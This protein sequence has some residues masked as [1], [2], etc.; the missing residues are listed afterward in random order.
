MPILPSS[1]LHSVQSAVNRQDRQG[2]RAPLRHRLAPCY[3]AHQ[4]ICSHHSAHIRTVSRARQEVPG[5]RRPS[6]NRHNPSPCRPF[7]GR[8]GGRGLGLPPLPFLPPTL[9]SVATFLPRSCHFLPLL[10]PSRG[11]QPRQ[12]PLKSGI[13]QGEHPRQHH[14]AAKTAM[15]TAAVNIA[16]HPGAA[17]TVGLLLCHRM[18]GVLSWP[19]LASPDPDLH[20]DISPIS[21]KRPSP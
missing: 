17:S 8:E 7:P 5:M 16:G 21:R 12:P 15:L 13:Q 1:L 10:P 18:E 11:R 9:P 20:P 4:K 3:T 14:K 6:A 19:R 2:T